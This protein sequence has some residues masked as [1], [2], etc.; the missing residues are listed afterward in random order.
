MLLTNHK[1]ISLRCEDKEKLIQGNLK[2]ISLQVELAS[3]K[4]FLF[5]VL[6]K[7]KIC[8]SLLMFNII[9]YFAVRLSGDLK[10]LSRGLL[11]F[12]VV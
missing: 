2:Q 11:L 10:W 9:S 5:C 7:E 3:V 4:L 8:F 6:N 12:P 1:S